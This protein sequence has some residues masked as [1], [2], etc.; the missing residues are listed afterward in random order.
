MASLFVA[1][2]VV[3]HAQAEYLER[4][5]AALKNQTH[6]I[7]QI[8]VV[9]TASDQES[10][11]LAKSMGFGVVTPGD[12]RLG[13]A[14][15]AGIAALAEKPGWVWVLHED[16]IPNH[17]ALEKLA[18]AAEISPSVA[19]IGPKLLNLSNP[20]QIQ[21]MG[22][23]L[24]RFGRPFLQVQNE[25]DQGQ[26][27]AAGDALAVS[28]AGMLFA[29]AAWDLL[30][31]LDD[32]SPTLAQDLELGIKARAAGFRV[33]VEADARVLHEGLSLSGKRSRHWLQ[34]GTSAAISKA[35]IHLATLI[36]P[37]WLVVLGYLSLPVMALGSIPA[38]L[39]AKRPMRIIS[40]FSAWFWAWR[41]IGKR[42][43]A[44]QR[45]SRIGKTKGLRVFFASS[46]AIRKRRRAGL[47]QEPIQE[48]K[49][50][51]SL[52][53][54]NSGWLGLLPLLAAF[55]LFPQGALLSANFSPLS[56]SFAEVWRGTA[57]FSQSLPGAPADP[58]VWFYAAISF[59]SPQSPSMALSVF[60]FTAPAL[61]FFG[62]WLL[63]SIFVERI[64]VRNFVALA[65]S[66][67]PVILGA[68][69]RGEV[70]ELIA[71][72]TLPWVL[73]FLLRA[74]LA[75]NSARTWRWVGLSG[76]A[77]A[78][79]A[80][81]APPTAAFVA[82]LVFGLGI[83]RPAKFLILIWTLIPSGV[84]L[85]PL[86][87]WAIANQHLTLLT[88]GGSGFT[89]ASQYQTEL[90]NLVLVGLLIL[91][92][93]HGIFRSSI[94]LVIPLLAIGA[95][96][97]AGSFIQ[98]QA[99]SMPLFFLGCLALIILAATGLNS[100]HKRSLV[101]PTAVLLLAATAFSG[102]WFGLFGKSMVSFGTD[103]LMPALV[104]AAAESGA[105]VKTLVLTPGQILKAK[106]SYGNGLGQNEKYLTEIFGAGQD[107]P[108]DQDLAIAKLAASLVAGNS[109]DISDLVSQ[110]GVDFVLL[111]N[112]QPALSKPIELSIG[113][114]PKFQSAGV[115]DFGSL[116]RVEGSSSEASVKP[117]HRLRDVQLWAIALFALLAIPTPASIRGYRRAKA[118]ELK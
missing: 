63:A 45:L 25:Y 95:L 47:V 48:E 85:Y 117:D 64:W 116:W 71:M 113:A 24:T 14:I 19:I 12:L 34:G 5:L 114:M 35:H 102:A 96:S 92:S 97:L 42:F 61:A 83:F 105:E 82:L 110:T 111:D 72:A 6:P 89:E 21:Q 26:H 22:L 30:G 44:K 18:R 46:R 81:S 40:Q 32:T 59:L 62:S 118:G 70:V 77:L 68:A 65:V 9:E 36:F 13:A 78:V 16:S 10:I 106:I 91:L 41:T 73:F 2:I 88:I 3:S 94:G 8:V 50:G 75:Y 99:S 31:G 66:L 37:W 23:T 54:S 53:G 49:S 38:N 76:L 11:K 58:L 90:S 100:L 74:T 84:L 57:A 80:I 60:V 87:S 4:T 103:Q 86:L 55:Q 101:I 28:T 67:S 107:Q 17:D 27:D 108:G 69:L 98:F 43:A 20:I 7:T 29:T 104:G 109:R 39:L 52:F 93:L 79:L 112:S 115:T 1:A 56:P 51:T 15:D 33:V